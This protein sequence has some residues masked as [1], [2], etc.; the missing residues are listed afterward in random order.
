MIGGLHYIPVQSLSVATAAIASG[1]ALYLIEPES[2]V[3]RMS[4]VMISSGFGWVTA[5]TAHYIAGTLWTRRLMQLEA[6]CQATALTDADKK[7]I[8]DFLTTV[9]NSHSSL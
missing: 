5:Q 2:F 9:P 8:S 3:G 7:A 6:E 4:V 1:M